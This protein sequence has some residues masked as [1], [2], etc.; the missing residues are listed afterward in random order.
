MDF[1]IEREY[2]WFGNVN[3]EDECEPLRL[4][5]VRLAADHPFRYYDRQRDTDVKLHHLPARLCVMT[6][7][8]MLSAWFCALMGIFLTNNMNLSRLFDRLY[9]LMVMAILPTLHWIPLP[10]KPSDRRRIGLSILWHMNSWYCHNWVSVYNFVTHGAKLGQMWCHTWKHDAIRMSNLPWKQYLQFSSVAILLLQTDFWFMRHD[11]VGHH[12]ELFW[13]IATR[14]SDLDFLKFF[15]EYPLDATLDD[16]LR[17]GN[18]TIDRFLLDE[19]LFCSPVRS[20]LSPATAMALNCNTNKQAVKSAMAAIPAPKSTNLFGIMDT[21]A[22][23]RAIGN[24]SEFK[25]LNEGD[26]GVEL[27][28]I[29]AGCPTMGEGIVEYDITMGPGITQTL[30]LRAY[31]VPSL[32]ESVRLISPQG[33]RSTNGLRGAF[34]SHDNDDGRSGFDPTSFLNFASATMALI[35]NT[36]RQYTRS[37]FHTILA[38]ICPSWS[39]D[40]QILLNDMQLHLLR[41]SVSRDENN[42]NLTGTQK[43]LLR[44]HFHLGHIGFEHIKW[45]ARSG[46]IPVTNPKQFGS[47]DT[48]IPTCAACE[49]GK[50]HKRP[51]GATSTKTVK[52][53]SIRK[54]DLLP[55]QR[56]SMDHYQSALPGRLYTSKGSTAFQ[57]MYHGGTIFM[58]HASGR[59]DVRHQVN[60]NGTET[61][62]AKIKF[63]REAFNDGVPIQQ[64]HTDNGIFTSAQFVEEL[65]QSKQGVRYSG[66]G[67]AHQNAVAERAIQ[68]IVYMARTMMLHAAMRAPDGFIKAEHWPQTMDHA[69]WLYNRIPRPDSGCSPQEIWSRSTIHKQTV[70]TDSHVWGCP[71]YVLEPKLQKSGITIP[72]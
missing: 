30:R 51:T 46:F 49:F 24:K 43:E 21:G 39:S 64:Y 44:W 34:A 52:D 22:T 69:V 60:L 29:A 67:A 56:V 45:L 13:T 5:Q 59:V 48:Q 47:A 17:L 19:D 18:F 36:P 2:E 10:R 40:S 70:L 26:N 50:A 20:Q 37:R 54:G 53:M 27:K 3:F 1:A 8:I 66:A 32:G 72:K 31:W 55:G 42:Q 16:P 23:R 25:S 38:T 15:G 63:E 7:T 57:H 28:G 65:L 12:L 4:L 33:L 14:P 68:T 62:E 6:D 71:V 11:W 58:D 9:W 35:G 41:L 61:V